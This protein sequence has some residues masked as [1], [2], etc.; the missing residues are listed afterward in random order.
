MSSSATAA[1]TESGGTAAAAGS[2]G[3][4]IA[5]TA[6]AAAPLAA[7]A[8]CALLNSSVRS[9]WCDRCSCGLLLQACCSSVLRTCG[10]VVGTH[11]WEMRGHSCE[12]VVFSTLQGCRMCTADTISCQLTAVH[13]THVTHGST[14]F[15]LVPQTLEMKP[16]AHPLA[17]AVVSP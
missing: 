14:T 17:W 8:S 16:R 10:W 3:G 5:A 11:S 2:A 13:V 9:C 15:P 7:V 12:H 6:A 1:I 4:S